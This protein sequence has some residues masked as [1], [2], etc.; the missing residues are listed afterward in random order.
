M[1]EQTSS[2]LELTEHLVSLIKQTPKDIIEKI[3]YLIQGRLSPEYEGIE[4]GI[5]EKMIIKSIW[6]SSGIAIK[7]IEQEYSILGDLGE[8]AEKIMTKRIQTTF[9]KDIVTVERVY[10]TFEKIA[11]S[12]GKN[13]QL[14][15]LRL[16]SSLLNDSSPEECKYLVKL[17][18]GTL[19]LGIADFTLM[20]ALAIAYTGEKSNRKVIEN[21]YNMCSDL[22]IVAN[23]IAHEGL[24]SLDKIKIKPLIPI[25][26]MLAERIL[27]A[28]EA[29]TKT[30]GNDIAMEYKLDGERVQI[31]K[32]NNQVELFSRSLER[33]TSYYPDLVNSVM[34]AKIENIIL[35]A[36]IVP[37][38]P[39]TKKILPFQNLMHRRRKYN[40]EI[41][42]KKYPINVY[43]FDLLYLEGKDKINLSYQNRRRDLDNLAEKLDNKIVKII[44]IKISN[45]VRE[46]EKFFKNSINLGYEGIML[47]QL[48]STYRA[49]AREFSWMKLKMEYSGNLVDT[50]DLVVIG[51]SFGRGRRVGKYGSLLLAVYDK[52]QD[53]FMSVTKVGTGFTDEFL[54]ELYT[55]LVNIILSKKHA[56]V[57]TNLK[58]DV[59]FEPKI[60]IEVIS[61]EITISPIHTAG[62]DI[63]KKGYGLALRFPKFTGKIRFD[64]NPEDATSTKE[65]ID[66][67]NKQKYV[68][69]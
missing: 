42:K 28:K 15:K 41:Y 65:L 61:S 22:G 5:A 8:V 55:K 44:S 3:I 13:S 21:A 56:K 18:L 36:E 30:E 14:S 9:F 51:A 33:I 50:L 64:K 23:K 46:I 63:I 67:F 24:D 16:L 45:N 66:F 32:K 54:N 1:M 20:D 4:L 34:D 38:Q 6:N 7:E 62:R 29:L 12:I 58:M 52:D 26:P 49:G 27:S 37:I 53:L 19:R 25:R 31:H 59:W 11:T 17:A 69:V 60:V 48:D 43:V 68:H 2:R 40:V 57:V 35:E 39:D 10:L 47:K